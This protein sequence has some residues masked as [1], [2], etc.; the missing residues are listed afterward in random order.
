MNH[1]ILFDYDDDNE[2]DEAAIVMQRRR[3]FFYERIK[4]LELYD[5]NNIN[6]FRLSKETFHIL[7]I[8]IKTV[9]FKYTSQI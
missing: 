2:I 7:W 3:R 1:R 8:L 4:Y 5:N 9:N 6:K